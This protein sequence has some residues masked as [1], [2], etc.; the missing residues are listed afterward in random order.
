MLVLIYASS[1]DRG[2][3]VY[4][5]SL[6]TL[7]AQRLQASSGPLGCRIWT[8]ATGTKGY[9]VARV[10]GKIRQLR[11]IIYER[12]RRPLRPGE[13]VSTDCGERL[14]LE[15]SHLVVRP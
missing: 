7:L 3:V 8:G 4:T 9:P 15:P 1:S 10:Y 6:D 12:D 13:T 2:K 14:C 5:M 11:R